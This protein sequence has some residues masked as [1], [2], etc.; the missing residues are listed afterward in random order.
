MSILKSTKS[1]RS[2][3]AV[4]PK[5]LETNG[6]FYRTYSDVS[7][8]INYSRIYKD[9]DHSL[10]IIGHELIGGD[11]EGITFF[12]EEYGDY[13][14]NFPVVN[15]DQLDDVFRFWD[16]EVVDFELAEKILVEKYPYCK[17][18]NQVK[19]ITNK[20]TSDISSSIDAQIMSKLAVY[21]KPTLKTY[22]GNFKKYK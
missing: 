6:W 2:S 1:G 4:D 20:L 19:R 5:Y 17:A 10:M 22:N 15:L 8:E 12:H 18:I 3:I 16:T 9:K 7:S 13:V 11:R 14:Y 21:Y